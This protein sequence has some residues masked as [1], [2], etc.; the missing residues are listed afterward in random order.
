MRIHKG[1]VLPAHSGYF[2][3]FAVCTLED[4]MLRVEIR[5]REGALEEAAEPRNYCVHL[6]FLV[7]W[8]T[9]SSILS[10]PIVGVR[11]DF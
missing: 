4:N 9:V 10:W 5:L 11:C 8:G 6:N 1:A 2:C 3:G 7:V